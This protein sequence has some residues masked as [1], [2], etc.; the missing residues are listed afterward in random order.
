MSLSVGLFRK[1]ICSAAVVAMSCVISV[2]LNAADYPS[3]YSLTSGSKIKLKKAVVFEGEDFAAQRVDPRTIRERFAYLNS[4]STSGFLK[5]SLPNFRNLD[6][7]T[8][9]VLAEGTELTVVGTTFDLSVKRLIVKTPKGA[10]IYIAGGRS[11]EENW[12]FGGESGGMSESGYPPSPGGISL[13]KK[14]MER[15]LDFPEELR[16]KEVIIQ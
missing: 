3:L 11:G 7:K 1:V 12:G 2:S 9:Y 5:F 16:L 15:Y 14:E 10:V 4:A 8:T 6:F 13:S